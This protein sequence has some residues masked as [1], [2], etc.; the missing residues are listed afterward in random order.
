MRT[1]PIKETVGNPLAG[2]S[3]EGL[4]VCIKSMHAAG[5]RLSKPGNINPK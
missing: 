1:L 4:D 5:N 3:T 2:K